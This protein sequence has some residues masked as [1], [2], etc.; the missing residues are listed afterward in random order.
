MSTLAENALA[1]EVAVD[2]DVAVETLLRPEVAGAPET[3]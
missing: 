1:R 2:E 3:D